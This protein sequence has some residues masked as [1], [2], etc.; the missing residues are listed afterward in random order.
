MVISAAFY[1]VIYKGKL[2]SKWSNTLN[3]QKLSQWASY[4]KFRL[5]GFCEKPTKTKIKTNLYDHKNPGK[6]QK[7]FENH[8]A[9]QK[10]H[11]DFSVYTI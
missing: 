7:S 11:W 1:A 9:A 6:I 10:R 3:S 8:P 2:Y 4:K 5:S